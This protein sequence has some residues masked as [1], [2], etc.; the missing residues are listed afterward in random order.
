VT[1]ETRQRKNPAA[2]TQR[3]WTPKEAVL[4]DDA[5]RAAGES[6]LAGCCLNIESADAAAFLQS[7]GITI[8]TAR[9]FRLGW[10][11]ADRFDAPENWGLKPWENAKGNAGR[12]FL[13]AGLVIPT[14]R[15]AGLYA[16]NI[17]RSVVPDG[18]A[19]YRHVLGSEARAAYAIGPQHAPMRLIVEGALDALT[20]AQEAPELCSVV[21]V[22]AGN[23]PDAQAAAFIRLTPVVM[24]ACDYDEAGMKNYAFWR[25]N[26]S[27]RALP[28]LEKDVNAMHVAGKFSI[29]EWIECA[30]EQAYPM[31]ARESFLT[32]ENEKDGTNYVEQKIAPLKRACFKSVQR[33]CV[34][35]P[36]NCVPGCVEADLYFR[37]AAGNPYFVRRMAKR[38]RDERAHFA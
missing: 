6:F 29:R 20:I 5:W 19:R 17:R 18:E 8:E 22:P 4:P 31:D 37:D 9:R 30:I 13:P 11:P 28:P 10:N 1:P 3:A 14:F 38:G 23:R 7:R 34:G 2:S 32:P 36:D 24:Y 25:D 26:F 27:C 21:A 15:K 33:T 12:L 16:L 35:Y